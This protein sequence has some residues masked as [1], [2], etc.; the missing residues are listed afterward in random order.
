MRTHLCYCGGIWQLVTLGAALREARARGAVCED[1]QAL[2]L[3]DSSISPSM[4]DNIRHVAPAIWS[5]KDIRTADTLKSFEAAARNGLWPFPVAEWR[6]QFQHDAGTDCV[7][8]LWVAHLTGMDDKI[9]FELF[10]KSRISIFEDGLGILRPHTCAQ[11]TGRDM[12]N[13]LISAPGLAVKG[14]LR[15]HLASQRVSN[16]RIQKHYLRR[17]HGVY[18]FINR[19]FPLPE[20]LSRRP[21]REVGVE[22]MK[23]TLSA[24]ADGVAD[25]ID[26]NGR[27]QAHRPNEVLFLAQ[28]VYRLGKITREEELQAY[29]DVVHSLVE[30][31]YVV[32]WKEHPRTELPFFDD[33][34]EQFPSAVL[35]QVDFP[36][37]F[38]IEVYFQRHR[39]PV[40][41]GLHSGSLLYLREIYGV[42]AYSFAE[43]LSARN[44][45]YAQA[46]RLGARLFDSVIPDVSTMPAY[47]E[48]VKRGMREET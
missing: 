11:W 43:A 6:K 34:A 26:G 45:H 14:R 5:W 1:D 28:S 29:A 24:Y 13:L 8:D 35:K 38:P 47:D 17:V 42:R 7:D 20:P 2:L 48:T 44:E 12:R 40:C 31:N 18:S 41:V 33:L 21:A 25:R 39:I 3:I 19:M 22:A 27:T 23:D 16:W 37:E 32:L 15:N 30:R 4:I 46:Y 9:L 36:A 10:P